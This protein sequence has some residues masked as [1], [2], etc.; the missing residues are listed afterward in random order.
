M[1]FPCKERVKSVYIILLTFLGVSKMLKVDLCGYGVFTASLEL[2]AVEDCDDDEDGDE[3]EEGEGEEELD[4]TL[5]RDTGGGPTPSS[6]RLLLHS[7]SSS[8]STSSVT[9]F[10]TEKQKINIQ[11]SRVRERNE[12]RNNVLPLQLR[13]DSLLLF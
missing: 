2:E 7:S 8:G 9:S 4:D 13:T 6:E 1:P 12:L 3:G 11:L 5:L 10:A